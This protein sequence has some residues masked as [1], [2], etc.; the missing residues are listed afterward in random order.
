MP[1]SLC[2]TLKTKSL[3]Q[4]LILRNNPKYVYGQRTVLNSDCEGSNYLLLNVSVLSFYSGNPPSFTNSQK[5]KFRRAALL[6]SRKHYFHF[7]SCTF[8]LSLPSKVFK[9]FLAM[10]VRNYSNS[11]IYLLSVC[12]FPGITLDHGWYKDE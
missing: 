2:L 11:F 6:L 7:L 1:K 9:K 4:V 10:T 8:V 12:S 5:T 3:K